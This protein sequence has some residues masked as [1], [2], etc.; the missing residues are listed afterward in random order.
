M[1]KLNEGCGYTDSNILG[2]GN[3]SLTIANGLQTETVISSGESFYAHQNITV[4]E[5]KRYTLTCEI[6]TPFPI[7]DVEMKV[8]DQY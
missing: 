5:A 6:T 7:M 1:T 8:S 4:E 3:L 2:A